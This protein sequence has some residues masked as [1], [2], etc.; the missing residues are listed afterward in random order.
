VTDRAARV[1]ARIDAIYSAGKA[2]DEAGEDLPLY[3]HAVSPAQARQLRDL[4]TEE[5]VER[6]VEVGFAMGLS[7]LALCEALL[8][9]AGEGGRHTVIDPAQHH[10]RNAGLRSVAD[11]GVTDM[12]E[13]IP[14]ESQIA[15]PRLA[16]E[17]RSFDLAFID[18]DHRYEAVFVDIYYCLRLV[19]PGGLIVLDDVWMPSV[20]QAASYFERERGL[21]L[22]SGPPLLRERFRRRRWQ[23]REFAALRTPADRSEAH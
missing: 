7:C 11:A 16:A 19:K 4:A 23:S 15:L 22:E 17:G 10:W 13:V 2:L 5:R 3:H 6:T 14:D 1:R 12:V 18:G 21:S 20:A 9:S 8:R